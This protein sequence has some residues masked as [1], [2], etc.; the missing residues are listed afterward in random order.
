MT[1]STNWTWGN[2]ISGRVIAARVRQRQPEFAA[3]QTT[4]A[5]VRFDAPLNSDSFEYAKFDAA[6]TSMEQKV[7]SFEALGCRTEQI[8]NLPFDIKPPEFE[9]IIDRLNNDPAIKGIIVQ[10][11]VPP[12]CKKL[13]EDIA[14]E[15]DLDALAA[16]PPFSVPATSEGIVR[17]VE[18][19]AADAVTAVVGARGFVG[20]GVVSQLLDRGFEVL[21]IDQS[22]LGFIPEDLLKVRDADIVVSATGQPELLDE[23]HL[24]PYHRLVVDSGFIKLN[25][26]LYGDVRNSARTIPQ[27]YTPVPGG[28]GP[29]EMAVLME[30]LIRKELDPTVRA[31]E[32]VDTQPLTYFTRPQVSQQQTAWAKT[33]YPT[34]IAAFLREAGPQS[35]SADNAEPVVQKHDY[36]LLLDRSTS[37]LSV[38]GANDRGILAT[39]NVDQNQVISATGLTQADLQT[40]REGQRRR[41]SKPN[42][43][44]KNQL[45]L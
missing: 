28:V 34:A 35:D 18:P 13:V 23:R 19:F 15:K 40:W 43:P 10:Y 9:A 36:K 2:P 11:P 20:R 12:K 37:I 22:N 32:L 21:A 30:R 16:N 25:E 29:T 24:T 5:I 4:V 6:R 39:Y 8:P 1:D 3:Q 33:I 41:Q 45:E 26:Q 44:R 14:P 38:E 27:N 17:L 42:Q 31:W 7:K